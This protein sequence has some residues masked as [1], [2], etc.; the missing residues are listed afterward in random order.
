MKGN[1]KVKLDG[2]GSLVLR[3]SNYVTAGGEG[4]IYRVG[5][6]VV[7]IYADAGKMTRDG[8][9]E[10]IKLLSA[11][12]HPSILSP[13]GVVTDDGDNPVGF[14]MPFG[15]G[16]PMPRVFTADFRA[17]SGFNDAGARSL[18]AQM[19]DATQ[20]AHDGGA[21]MVDANEF[22]WIVDPA[23]KPLAIDV[24]SWA[25]G[26]WPA[27]VIMPSIRDWRA[28]KFDHGTDWFAWGI[29]AFQVFT[30]IHPYKGRLDGYKPSELERR[31]R[32]NA[33]VFAPGVRLPHSVRDFSCIP[34]PLLDWF[35]ATFAKGSRI[36][37]PSP[38]D[39][40]KMAPAARVLRAVIGTGAG[41]LH[42]KLYSVGSPVVRIWPCGAALLA[43]GDIVDLA[44]KAR[45]G[46]FATE[47]VRAG[48]GWLMVDSTG[49]VP[50]F[51]YSGGGRVYKMDCGL[52]VRGVFRSADR[53][54]V[55]TETDLVEV[56]VANAPDR[57]VLA[58]GQRWSARPNAT[59]WF[60]GV[61]IQDVL[62][63]A[64]LTLPTKTGVVQVRTPELNGLVPVAGV[65]NGR[66]AA[67]VAADRAGAY[68]RVE[69]SFDSEMGTYSVWTGANDGPDLNIVALPSGV[70]AT[71]VE[72]GEVVVFVPSNGNVNKVQD[73]GIATD[74]RLFRWDSKVVYI[75][76][77]AVW[78]MQVK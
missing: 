36:A 47:V 37:P 27:T 57:P 71:I 55:I 25:I 2:K 6:T 64:F 66:F 78:R 42:E 75:R 23:F 29:V 21:V 11:I 1:L 30:G 76:D 77:G 72:D 61:A 67:I 31:M 59:K 12:K 68:K 56:E 24:D 40:T 20:C 15:E 48:T 44:T 28:K 73:R 35:D 17:R 62:G 3:E 5:A 54:F 52:F 38:L 45:I 9:A 65:G 33:S 16:E 39:G 74:L 14:Y 13:A 69:F 4:A 32:D 8:M 60:D 7:K 18:T 22:N 43:S 34:A 19:R 41:L 46:G 53:I 50:S 58:I 49:G 51:Q 10:K 26:R 63:S 70:V